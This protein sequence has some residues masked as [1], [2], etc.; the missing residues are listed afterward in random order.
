[1]ATSDVTNQELAKKWHILFDMNHQPAARDDQF[2]ATDLTLFFDYSLNPTNTFRILQ[3]PT[4]VYDLGGSRGENEWIASDTIFSHFWNLPWSVS[5]TGTR[6]RL[7]SALN[8]PTSLESQDNQKILTFGHTLQMNTMVAG[9]LL[10]SLRPFYRYNWNRFRTSGPGDVMGGRPL[11]QFTY[12]LSMVNSYNVSDSLSLNASASWVVI[13][14]SA[15]E[16]DNSTSAGG[17]LGQNPAGTYS[18]SLSANYS[19]TEKFGTYVGYFQGAQYIQDGRF[20]VYAYDPRFTRYSA[21]F[22]F[23]F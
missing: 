1:V 12:G 15:S 18:I 16:F 6:F 2:A 3:A 4:K 7:V 11:P 8:L 10:V 17:W 22:T 5:E 20:E 9:K 23:Y 19:W 13:Y 21:G 14:E